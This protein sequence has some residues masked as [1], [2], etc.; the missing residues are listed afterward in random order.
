MAEIGHGERIDQA[1]EG[2]WNLGQEEEQILEGV[3]RSRRGEHLDV[4]GHWEGNRR[5]EE[6]PESVAE[7]FVEG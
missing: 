5:V 4:V 7:E 6:L 2:P 1:E 3:L